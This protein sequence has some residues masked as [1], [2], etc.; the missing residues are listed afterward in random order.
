MRERVIYCTVIISQKYQVPTYGTQ[1][2]EQRADGRGQ[3]G[4]CQQGHPAGQHAYTV[5]TIP[6][7]ISSSF[8]FLFNLLVSR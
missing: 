1:H 4:H 3:G 6:F 7:T 8:K 5:D 2:L